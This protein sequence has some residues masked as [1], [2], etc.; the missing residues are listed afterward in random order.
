MKFIEIENVKAFD[1]YDD[2]FI[3]FCKKHEINIPKLNSLKGQ[4]I[5]LMTFKKNRNKYVDRDILNL[6]ISKIGFSSKDVIQLINKTDQWGLK[7]ITLERKFYTIPFPFI[8]VGL[9]LKKR[10]IKFS[11]HNRD[12]KIDYIKEYLVDNYINVPNEKWEVGHLDPNNP[13]GSEE[14]LV[15]QPPI[16]GK[17]RDRFK[18]DKMGL[19]KYP[20]PNEL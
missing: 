16:Q 20:T 8:Y 17:F 15:Y 7:H 10:D 11:S 14:N 1:K 6:F 4:V 5:A 2:E 9:H 3:K 12:E 18:F 19:I 13:D